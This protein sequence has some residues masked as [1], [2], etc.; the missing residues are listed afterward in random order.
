MR[1]PV[2]TVSNS[3]VRKKDLID[4]DTYRLNEVSEEVSQTRIKSDSI[5]FQCSKYFPKYYEFKREEQEIENKDK[6]LFEKREKILD[7]YEILCLYYKYLVREE[8]NNTSNKNEQL[9]KEIQRYLERLKSNSDFKQ[10]SIVGPTIYQPGINDNYF[11]ELK[12]RDRTVS[13]LVR[14]DSG[15]LSLSAKF[16]KINDK[17]IQELSVYAESDR[18]HEEN[19]DKIK[20]KKKN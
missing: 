4:Q 18:K 5:F 16:K 6:K 13:K 17:V 9:R 1:S 12:F 7:D 19:F 3:N 11:K 15:D 10:L 2:F 8:I 14:L 20:A